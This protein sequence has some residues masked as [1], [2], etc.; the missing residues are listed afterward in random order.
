MRFGGLLI[1]V[2]LVLGVGGGFAAAR[3]SPPD[4]VAAA[5]QEPVPASDPSV[6]GEDTA[7][8]PD[9]DIPA[10]SPDLELEPAVLV[11]DDG[12]RVEVPVPTGWRRNDL[13][14]GEARWLLESNPS[15]SY[16][17][18]VHALPGDVSLQAMLE[19]RHNAWP[20]D[21]NITDV[22]SITVDD[23]I[24]LLAGDFVHFGY[25]RIA[26]VRWVSFDGTPMA[27]LEIAWSGRLR[28]EPAMRALLSRMA[29][30]ARRLKKSQG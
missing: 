25:R 7:V 16:S 15:G 28:D 12:R 23:D 8:K 22:R 10:L 18:R 29:A 4:P 24:A 13:R 9:A 6:P 27:S 17:V 21:P 1:A 20:G 11:G 19:D 2:A 5:S 26:L 30:D 3:L 14:E